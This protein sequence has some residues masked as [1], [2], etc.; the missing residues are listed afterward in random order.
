MDKDGT[1]TKVCTQCSLKLPLDQFG[2][3]GPKRGGYQPFCRACRNSKYTPRVRASCAKTYS[4]TGEIIE[5]ICTKC[6]IIKPVD[7]FH[8]APYRKLGILDACKDCTNAQQN[9]RHQTKREAEPAKEPRIKDIDGILHKKCPGCKKLL[10][11]TSFYADKARPDGLQSFCRE[12]RHKKY[13]NPDRVFYRKARIEDYD[14]KGNITAR[15]CTRCHLV[16]SLDHFSINKTK[17]SGFNSSCKECAR[18]TYQLRRDR[19]KDLGLNPC[20]DWNNRYKFEVFSHYSGGTPK[21]ECCDSKYLPHLTIDH[22]AQ[23]GAKHRKELKESGSRFTW[24]WLKDNNYPEG[25]RVLCMNC[26]RT[27]YWYGECDCK[28]LSYYAGN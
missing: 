18:I 12:C 2:T 21:C 7:Q 19:N 1:V 23:D 11:K 16:K 4:Q 24:K 17:K 27:V 8:K 9:R 3:W 26:N 15:S 20:K 14:E 13:G 25:F 5:K 6:K 28:N 10:P 22:I